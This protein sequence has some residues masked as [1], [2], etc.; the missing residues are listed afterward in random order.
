ML[1][2]FLFWSPSKLF[3]T[4]VRLVFFTFKSDYVTCLKLPTGFLSEP[5]KKSVMVISHQPPLGIRPELPLWH[6]LQ[7]LCPNI[8]WFL[9]CHICWFTS[10]W[11]HQIHMHL[12]LRFSTYSSIFFSCR[13]LPY[14]LPAFLRCH[15]LN[16]VYVAIIFTLQLSIFLSSFILLF[17]NIYFTYILFA[18]CLPPK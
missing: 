18:A 12:P 8:H 1:S 3:S 16:D 10:P 9:F 6:H 15:L 17:N 4:E 14:L 11:A 2:L 13:K 5:E 7:Y